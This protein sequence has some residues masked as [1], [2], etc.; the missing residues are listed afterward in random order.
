MNYYSGR[1]SV[2]VRSTV[3]EVCL[4]LEDYEN[5]AQLDHELQW[6]QVDMIVNKRYLVRFKQRLFRGVLEYALNIDHQY[7]GSA[8][9]N[10]AFSEHFAE[11]KGKVT[12]TPLDN[13]ACR[14]DLA[15]EVELK[16][17][18]PGRIFES[19]Q[20]DFWHRFLDGLR[21]KAESASIDA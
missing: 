3:Q 9:W 20:K 16:Q 2:E 10:L 12:L 4:V 7:P 6:A 15:V 18:L 19:L 11:H 14:V 5:Y 13:G 8:S 17:W 1:H 21:A